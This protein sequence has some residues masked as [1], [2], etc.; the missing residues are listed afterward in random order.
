MRSQKWYNESMKS[1]DNLTTTQVNTEENF[2]EKLQNKCIKLEQEVEELSAKVLWYEEQIRKGMKQKYEPSSE[3][4]PEEQ[5]SIFNEAEKEQRP[6]KTEPDI[7]EIIYKR[8]K[9]KRSNKNKWDDLPVEVI[10]Y[11]LEESEKSCPC[12]NNP[13][14]RMKK[15]IH[16]KLKVIPATIK[17]VRHEQNVY[18][19]RYCEK[20]EITTPI[21][22]AKMPN[23]VVPGSIVSPSLL[24]Y[25]MNRKYNEAIPLYRQEQQ[26]KNFGIDI[27]RQNLANWTIKGSKWLEIIY[28]N[29]HTKILKENF[30]HADETTMQVLDEKGKSPGSKSYM[31]LYAT[32]EY[33]PPIFLY[34]Y[35]PSR[36]GGHPKNFLKGFKG[37]L[38]TD[39]YPGYNNIKDVTI[40]GCWAHARRGFIDTLKALPKDSKTSESIACEGRN[41]C[42]KLFNL[43]KG[44]SGLPPDLRYEKR[45]EHSKDVLEAFLAWLNE[46]KEKVLPKSNLGKAINYCLNQWTKLETFLK[47]GEIELSNNR[48]ERAI[49]PF[50]IGRKNWLFSKS[51]HG[52]T[53]SAIIYSIVETAKANG[54]NPFYYLEYLF[55]KLPNIDTEDENQIEELLPW[56]ETLPSHIKVSKKE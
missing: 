53:A 3:K 49:K 41:Y 31:W 5:L 6:D 2:I 34:E 40:A 30:L 20:N 17:I 43:E 45:L 15:E 52:A 38:Q 12:C 24:A 7:E 56:S 8:K 32:G 39:G 4:T 19:C 51:P 22:K 42:N 9:A 33:G 14:H 21:I 28:D 36:S 50:V 16:K 25:T 27:T 55:E 35:Q 1:I 26:F 10:E 11:D 46:Y 47:D 54:L 23:F 48:A 37:Y 13:L 18:A 29:L 44:F